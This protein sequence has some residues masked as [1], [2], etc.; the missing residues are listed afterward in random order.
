YGDYSI[1]GGSLT[2]N[3][4]TTNYSLSLAAP[5][6]WHFWNP[7]N[8]G[9]WSGA[10]WTTGAPGVV[11]DTAYFGSAAAPR[12]VTVDGPQTVGMLAFNSAAKYTIS[13]TQTI[14]LAG[15]AGAAA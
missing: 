11:G 15:N 2:L 4:G 1:G 9:S 13:G 7:S 5:P 10:N 8:S 3:K 6:T 14:T 12:T